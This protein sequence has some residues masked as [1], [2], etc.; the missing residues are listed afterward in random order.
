[1]QDVNRIFVIGNLVDDP[2]LDRTGSGTPVADFVVASTR[3]WTSKDG[4]KHEDRLCID[5]SAFG[6]AANSI[7]KHGQRG[8]R[9][10]VEGRL[11]HERWTGHDGQQHGKHSVL[12]QT[13][14][15]LSGSDLKR[16]QPQDEPQPAMQV[17]TG[18]GE[19]AIPF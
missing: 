14:A 1:M 12:A 18:I 13:I 5:C 2:I 15:F 11:R 19:D 4:E 7:A 9:V 10:V 3:T 16:E 17:A 8:T 6:H